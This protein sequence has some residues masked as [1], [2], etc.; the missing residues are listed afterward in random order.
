MF[1]FFKKDLSEI[2][3]TK[4]QMLAMLVLSNTTG[5]AMALAASSPKRDP[6][7]AYFVILETLA[8]ATCLVEMCAQR[9][10]KFT[11]GH[12]ALAMI[13]TLQ[14]HY[15]KFSKMGEIKIED[16]T[17]DPSLFEGAA[18]DEFLERVLFYAARDYQGLGITEEMFDEFCKATGQYARLLKNSDLN[19]ATAMYQATI[20]GVL[21]D[22]VTNEYYN[23]LLQNTDEIKDRLV[24]KIER[25]F[26]QDI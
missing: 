8:F 25:L 10:F 15:G 6:K 1:N 14:K 13:Q 22:Q 21:G 4:Y 20:F 23:F 11:D 26:K 3:D 16:G 18:S 7:T 24:K 12:Q 5:S 17:F 19:M 9:K 2:S